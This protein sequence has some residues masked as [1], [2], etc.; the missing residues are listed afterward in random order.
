MHVCTLNVW[1]LKNFT[2]AS[3]YDNQ[4]VVGRDLEEKGK[5]N[6]YINK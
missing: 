4:Y 2:I 5:I 3:M 6:T 1:Y